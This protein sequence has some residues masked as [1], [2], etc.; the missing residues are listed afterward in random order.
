MNRQAKRAAGGTLRLATP[1]D[2]GAIECI[3]RTAYAGYLDRIGKP[4]GP[5][6][7][8]YAALV[9]EGVVRVLEDAHGLV[10]ILVLLAR[11]GYL[12]LDNVAVAPERQG[13][14]IGRR[15]LEAAEAEAM[16]RGFDELRLYT[17]AAMH[18][19]LAMYPRLGWE[20]YGRAEEAGY[21]RVFFRRRLSLS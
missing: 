7:D 9:A 2:V 12:L 19:N 3:V 13:Q 11:P 1:A 21:Q 5:M 17:N 18:E 4:P 10:G 16:Q 14:G 15:L 6:L 20:E 8:D